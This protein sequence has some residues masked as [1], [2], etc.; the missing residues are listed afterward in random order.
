M[1][2]TRKPPTPITLKN[3]PNVVSEAGAFA[4]WFSASRPVAVWPASRSRLA[5]L[6]RSGSM[7]APLLKRYL[8][9]VGRHWLGSKRLPF[10]TCL[11]FSDTGN[12][13]FYLTLRFLSSKEHPISVLM[14]KPHI[15]GPR[16]YMRHMD[17]YAR[18]AFDYEHAQFIYRIP[19]E[20]ARMT[21]IQ[22]GSDPR[23]LDH[24]WRKIIALD[25]D[26]SAT[27]GEDGCWM[28]MPYS[29]HP[30]TYAGDQPTGAMLQM[31]RSIRLFFGGNV[32]RQKYSGL[33]SMRSIGER[34]QMM[35][36]VDVIDA[37]SALP[38]EFVW[39]LKSEAELS[40]AL[41]EGCQRSIVLA[42]SSECRIP[43]SRWSDTLARCQVF[44]AP[45]GVIMPPC[46]NIIEAM[47]VGCIPLT[48]Y[49]DWFFPP[50]E[51]GL[52]CLRFRDADELRER[53]LEVLAADEA[54]LESMRRG[55]VEYYDRYL[56]P[57]GFLER[58]RANQAT[59]L[60]LF[61]NSEKSDVLKRVHPASVLAA[62]RV[63]GG[64]IGEHEG[65]HT[66]TAG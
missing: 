59:R 7:I 8:T 19:H 28:I 39:R 36:R 53:V 54:S 31:R 6:E 11:S 51:H 14:K 57:E 4:P 1:P 18:L 20:S 30:L 47:A 32:D 22:D 43:A 42:L 13:Y 65:H 34:F 60:R 23:V 44:L 9:V 52:N 2:W 46:H 56:A 55:V 37:L 61:V 26:V 24:P 27:P 62:G 35:N 16:H 64:N 3:G 41:E 58:L 49:A 12:R 33:D 48:N 25:Q 29:M 21:L 5:Y 17:D 63:Q 45:P 66:I 38:A 15:I 10:D 40:G 50:L